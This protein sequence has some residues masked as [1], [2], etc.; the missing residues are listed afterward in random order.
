MSVHFGRL[1]KNT[2]AT[3]RLKKE[4]QCVNETATEFRVMR[5]VEVVEIDRFCA[6]HV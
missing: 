4:A 2:R 6:Q 1:D 5:G 3:C